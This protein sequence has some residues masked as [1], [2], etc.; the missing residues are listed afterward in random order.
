L[1][2]SSGASVKSEEKARS[3]G[4]MVSG[5]M[6][7]DLDRGICALNKSADNS[8]KKVPY[9]RGSIIVSI[10]SSMLVDLDRRIYSSNKSA[11]ICE[12]E[13]LPVR[14]YIS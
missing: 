9:R 4:M 14:W 8:K 5:S 10:H 1:G 7:V 6:L 3:G 11:D 2:G 12:K 13:V